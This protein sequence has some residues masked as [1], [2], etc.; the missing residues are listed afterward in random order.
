VPREPRRLDRGSFAGR[1]RAASPRRRG[2]PPP[3]RGAA[4]SFGRVREIRTLE[5][6]SSAER[7]HSMHAGTRST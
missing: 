2:T 4:D 7:R 1:R 3:V 5:P 6:Q